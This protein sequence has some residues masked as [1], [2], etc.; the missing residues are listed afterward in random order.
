MA[1]FAYEV[2][3]LLPH[4]DA[5]VADIESQ[6]VTVTCL[7]ARG[8]ADVRWLL[9]LRRLLRGAPDRR[10]ARP[11]ACLGG[12]R[13]GRRV[14]DSPVAPA[15]DGHDRAQPLAEPRSADPDGHVAHRHRRRRPAR[16][17]LGGTR[18]RCRPD[19][20]PSTE[21]VRHG[22]DV[23]AVAA[24]LAD[25]DAVRRELGLDGRLVV[26]TVANMRA[27]KGWL[28]L[29]AAARQVLDEVGRRRLPRR[30]PGSDGGGDSRSARATRSRRPLSPPRVPAR[31]RANHG[32]MR[33][34]LPRVPPRGP[35]DRSHGSDGPRSA[36]RRDRCRRLG[37]ARG[38]SAFTAASSRRTVPISS[39]ARSSS[40]SRTTSSAPARRPRCGRP[41]STLSAERLDQAGRGDLR[42]AHTVVTD[43]RTTQGTT[44]PAAEADHWRAMADERSAELQRLKRR[45]LVRAALALDRRLEPGRRAISPRW[46]RWRAAA[47]KAA[48]TAGA[49]ASMPDRGKRR[50]ALAAEVA[51][52][53]P[54]PQRVANGRH[55][56]RSA[57]RPATRRLI[58]LCFL[59]PTVTPLEEGW[60]R[61][62]AAPCAA[63][64]WR[65]RRPLS[66]PHRT[67]LAVTEHDLRVRAEGFDVELR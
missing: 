65:P 63:T 50:A 27:T 4:K 10:R 46:Q 66:I 61:R 2:A 41:P 20:R 42:G 64:S 11:F 39:P 40:C 37:R 52:L 25:R 49:A 16:R 43:G 1:A 53:P 15:T 54:A 22:I 57:P 13:S 48:V 12:V 33:R 18:A 36:D 23:D 55:R 62:L 56:S 14:D 35:A 5:F 44:S 31:R 3:Y 51:A 28:D 30:R 6:G 32:G 59:P 26:G 17:L 45:P 7:G 21:V 58:S 24:T 8:S 47:R 19:C 34:V 38:R 9:R 67:G 60:M 29:L